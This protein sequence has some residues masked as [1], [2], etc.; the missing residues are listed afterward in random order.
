MPNYGMFLRLPT[1][2]SH[3]GHTFGSESVK[4]QKLLEGCVEGY[5]RVWHHMAKES[6]L[7]PEH[8]FPRL[9]IPVV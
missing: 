3:A 9:G 1:I 4:Q 7:P 6:H 5:P 8:P 2:D